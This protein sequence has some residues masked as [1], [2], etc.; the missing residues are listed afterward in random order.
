MS[1]AHD[2]IWENVIKRRQFP[3]SLVNPAPNLLC[4]LLSQMMGD[5]ITDLPEPKTQKPEEEEKEEKEEVPRKI[6]LPL[7]VRLCFSLSSVVTHK[8]GGD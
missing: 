1:I 7:S 4:R 3:P 2:L 6:S 8:L 5:Q